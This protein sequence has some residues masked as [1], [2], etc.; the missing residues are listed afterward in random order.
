MVDR[1]SRRDFLRLAGMVP[2]GA[3]L[4]PILNGLSRR[5]SVQGARQNILLVVFDAMTALNTSLY[6]YERDTTP[7]IRRL[8]E[9]AIVYQN[10]YASANFTPPST[11]TLLTGTMPW[12]HRA[13]A[14]DAPVIDQLVHKS[15][16]RA[17]GDYHRA[18]YAHNPLVLRYFDQFKT[19]IDDYVPISDLFL[20][21]DTVTNDLF[22]A[23]RDAFEIAWR[24]TVRREL[25]GGLAR[26]LFLSAFSRQDPTGLKASYER[27]F[28]LGLPSTDDDD[29]FVLEMA[30]D[31]LSAEARSMPRPFFAYYHLLPPHE[32]YR[33]HR[34]FVGR[35]RNDGYVPRR[36][37]KDVFRRQHGITAQDMAS[38]R[39][40]YDEYLLY[41][42]REFS[43]LFESLDA[44]GILND[45][46]L[47]LTSDHG[48]LFERNLI[49]HNTP[50]LFQPIL[51]IP[52]VI[53]EPGRRRRLDVQVPTSTVDLLPTLLHMAGA[54]PVEW[55]EGQVLP[56]F[57]GTAAS[58]RSLYSIHPRRNP[59]S[60][61]LKTVS[62]ML[63]R[64][65]R[66]LTY[67]SGYAELA[68]KERVELYDLENDPGE[69][70][71]LVQS[72]PVTAKEM[73]AE[74]KAKLDEVNQPYRQEA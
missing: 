21:Y 66:K 31:H 10:H 17:L 19:D 5:R 59:P 28:P 56:P 40:E 15:I 4:Q 46:W 62:L 60:A 14:I 9:G 34:E 3:V 48:E 65:S 24:R 36:K 33:T 43:R 47:I 72:E 49:G 52:L 30:V 27:D 18:A 63:L 67:Y 39:R 44:D 71:D 35:F 54:P 23:D 69:L 58:E 25:N 16:Y 32:P 41:V 7:Q 1:L 22:P 51:R 11:A 70:H 74:L 6:G 26:S 73:L 45:T 37:P 42:D 64:G 12:T 8:A 50:A 53:F 13:F 29:A 20:S 61:P 55:A 38:A 57:G 68:G 2:S